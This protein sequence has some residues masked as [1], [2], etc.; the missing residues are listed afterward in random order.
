MEVEP[1][2]MDAD[3]QVR[4]VIERMRE[5]ALADSTSEPVRSAVADA[6]SRF[7]DPDIACSI[8]HWIKSR[9]QFERD[10]TR[11][12]ELGIGGD[13]V[14]VEVLTR[15]VDLLTMRGARGDCDDYS[16]LA[17]SMLIAAGRPVQFCTV[18]ANSNEPGKFSHVYVETVDRHGRRLPLDTSHG[19]YP[20]WEVGRF[21]SVTRFESWPVQRACTALILAAAAGFYLLRKFWR[22]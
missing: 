20:G 6:A 15:P 5:Y 11:N 17:A 19:K 12:R 18:A 13:D 3:G 8:F 22:L 21:V 14:L 7:P 1:L 10:E 16:M 9:V 2:P 4:A